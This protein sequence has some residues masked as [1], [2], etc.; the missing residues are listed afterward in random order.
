MDGEVKVAD[1]E[2]YI[3]FDVLRFSFFLIKKARESK[4]N[5]I[6]G[7]WFFHKALKNYKNL[8]KNLWRN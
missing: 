7:S 3:V 8:W 5:N 6:H 4:R 2:D 1:M